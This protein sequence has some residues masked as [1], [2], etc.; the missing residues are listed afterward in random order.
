MSPQMK[1]A[2]S[3]HAIIAVLAAVVSIALAGLE[4]YQRTGDVTG[5][6]IAGLVAASVVLGGGAVFGSKDTQRAEAVKEGDTS[7]LSPADVGY[8]HALVN[9]TRSR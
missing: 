9:I 1:V 3:R 2:L 8:E 4:E 7:K 6:A 5:A